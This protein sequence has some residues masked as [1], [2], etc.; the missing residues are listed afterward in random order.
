MAKQKSGAAGRKRRQRRDDF[1]GPWQHAL[2]RFFEPFLALLFPGIHAQIDWTQRPE[3]LDKALQKLRPRGR[4]KGVDKLVRVRWLPGE[5]SRT[6]LA[7]VL[8]HVE[9]QAQR[10]AGFERRMFV[11]H[12]RLFDRDEQPIV[13]LAVLADPSPGWRP[14]S[15]THEIGGCRLQLSFPVAKLK[16]LEPRWRELERTLN[17]FAVVVMAHLKTQAT[18][19][20]PEE[21]AHAKL[22]LS[23][24]LL[25]RG[26]SRDDILEL[27]RFVDW[28]MALPDD[29]QER[30]EATLE[31]E[32]REGDMPHL[33]IWERRG[34]EEGK[35]EGKKEGQLEQARRAVLRALE[36]RFEKVPLRLKHAIGRVEEL[37]RLDDLHELAIVADSMAA[38]EQG[39]AGSAPGTKP[40]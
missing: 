30:H 19:G 14:E 39:L 23:R 6:G 11:Y 20:Q 8:V 4:R 26:W 33:T 36:L 7:L 22:A 25:R 9:V 35:K 27:Y 28:L 40:R 31:R 3:F 18:Q 2:E 24:M 5:L 16:D 10:Q 1:D 29:L 13:S 17:P 12:Y 37:E 34:I 32:Q 38:F 21:R 15:Y